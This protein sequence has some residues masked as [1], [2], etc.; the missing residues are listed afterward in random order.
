[1][2]CQSISRYSLLSGWEGHSVSIEFTKTNKD[3]FTV[4]IINTGQG[5]EYHPKRG[6]ENGILKKIFTPHLSMKGF[7]LLT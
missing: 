5:F 2:D 4:K 1:M 6:Y 3:T 7:L